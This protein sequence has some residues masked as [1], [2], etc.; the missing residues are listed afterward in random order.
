MRL[1]SPQLESAGRPRRL[2][3]IARDEY[4]V[5][6]TRERRTFLDGY[7][8]MDGIHPSLK[9]AIQHESVRGRKHH[10]RSKTKQ[11]DRPVLLAVRIYTASSP[12]QRQ[13]RP[14]LAAARIALAISILAI[15]L[16]TTGSFPSR[17]MERSSG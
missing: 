8:H 14:A 5:L 10:F 1:G 12:L 7:G 17:S 16:V 9:P 3:M 2:V 13:I 15:S 6:V 4:N 11:C